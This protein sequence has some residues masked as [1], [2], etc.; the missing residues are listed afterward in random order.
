MATP[1]VV[2][3]LIADVTNYQYN[4]AAIQTAVLQKLTDATN[5]TL[6]VVDPSNPFIFCLESAAVL[7]AAA[8]IK[9]EANT[10]KQ[11]ARHREDRLHGGAGGAWCGSRS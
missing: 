2:D 10:R 6:S 5:G 4:P 8:C 11:C 1:T 9:N 3:T 7:T